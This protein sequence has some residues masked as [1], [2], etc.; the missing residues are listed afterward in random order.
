MDC[1]FKGGLV[2]VSLY[3]AYFSNIQHRDPINMSFYGYQYCTNIWF[4][5]WWLGWMYCITDD[6]IWLHSLYFNTMIWS[7]HN[8]Y[9]VIPTEVS[10]IETILFVN[11][12]EKFLSTAPGFLLLQKHIGYIGYFNYTRCISFT[13]LS[14]LA[15]LRRSV[16]E[17]LAFHL[18]CAFS[19]LHL[20][21]S[22]SKLF[23]DSL[24][25]SFIEDIQPS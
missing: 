1:S 18:V 24:G 20:H 6:I 10:R 22:P 3:S 5:M 19:K 2:F 14:V 17:L 9:W 25:K 8:Q 12:R 23:L 11:V 16:T 4:P 21:H 7:I 15:L 13:T